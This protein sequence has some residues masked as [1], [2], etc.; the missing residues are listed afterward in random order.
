MQ[1]GGSKD[2]EQEQVT[3][4]SNFFCHTFLFLLSIRLA[5]ER[6]TKDNEKKGAINKLGTKRGCSQGG[7]E[8]QVMRQRKR[9]EKEQRGRETKRE[10]GTKEGGRR[11]ESKRGRGGIRT[12]E[13]DEGRKYFLSKK[14]MVKK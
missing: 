8:G 10:A 7:E 9:R 1:K 5:S 2:W 3:Q 14:A 12:R 13:R 4:H 11:Q 6:I